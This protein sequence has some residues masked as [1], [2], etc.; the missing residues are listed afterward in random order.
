M[1]VAGELTAESPIYR[2]NARK[3]LFTRDDDG[4][5]RLVSLAGEISGTA[6]ALM[7]AFVGRSKNGR[8]VGLVNS[9]WS[10]LFGET[11]PEGLITKVEC[12]LKKDNYPKNNFFDLRMGIKLDDDRWAVESHKNYKFET[13]YRNSVFDFV[14]YVN[15]GMV[16]QKDNRTKL[17]YL[18][19]ELKAGRFWFGAG[20]SKG[21]GKC[22]LN[23]ATALQ[24]P[25][26]PPQTSSTAN[27][28]TLKLSFDAVNPL[29][30]GWPWGK[31]DPTTPSF[32]QVDG[33]F[34]IEGMRGLPDAIASR[35]AASM[36]GSILKVDEWKQQFAR[37][38][39][40]AIV[41]SLLDQP[42]Q[43]QTFYVLPEAAAKK[44]T[45]GKY[46]IPEK[47]INKVRSVMD[48]PYASKEALVA[49]VESLLGKDAKKAGKLTGQIEQ[50]VAREKSLNAANL[51]AIAEGLYFE[52]DVVDQIRSSF[53][54]ETALM[55]IITDACA[56]RMPQMNQD[57]DRQLKMLQSDPW[58]DLEITARREHL[59]IK[60]M[61]LEGKITEREWDNL[62]NPPGRIKE[63]VWRQFKTEH[64]KVAY[65]FMCHAGNLKKSIQNDRNYIE[66]LMHYRSQ[67]RQELAQQKN[68]DFRSGGKSNMEVSRKYGKPYDNMFMRMLVFTPSQ[69]RRSEWEVFI[70]GSTLKGAFRKRA[71]MV[72]NTLMEDRRNIQKVLDRLFGAQGKR[73]LLFFS[74]AYLMDP[75]EADNAFCS[76]D[77]VRMDPSTGRPVEEAKSDYLFLYGNDLRFT[78]QVDVQDVSEADLDVL[79]ILGHLIRDFTQGDIPIG[80]LKTSGFGW[81]GSIVNEVEWLTLDTR[82][83]HQRLFESSMEAAAQGLWRRVHLKDQEATEWIA[84]F[85]T[86]GLENTGQ[87][88]ST[89]PV[90]RA[91]EGFVSHSAFGG[92][93]GHLEIEGNTLTPMSIRE[94]GEP[95]LRKEVDGSTVYGWDF[96]SFSQP[97]AGLRKE[98]RTY[99][100]PSKSIKGMV[101]HIYS[102]GSNSASQSP[103]ISRLNPVDSLFGWVGGRPNEAIMGRVAFGFGVFEQP[104]LTWHKIPYPYG[105]WRYDGAAW[106]QTAGASSQSVRVADRWRVFP[107]APLAPFVESMEDFRPDTVQAVYVHAVMPGTRFRFSIRFWNL[108]KEELE[109]LIWCLALEDGLAHKMGSSRY[110]G[111]GSVSLRVL[112][113]SCLIDWKARYTK[114]AEQGWRVPLK[115]ADWMNPKTIANLEA[116]RKALLVK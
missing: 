9:M 97:E 80:S 46:A 78:F 8:N 106:K 74:D 49:E 93:C 113:E 43:E 23:L 50:Q 33:K 17:Y 3:T 104:R 39:P 31:L 69:Q 58:V 18:L 30:V 19:E 95:S 109:R 57:I 70:P 90:P 105:Q 114:G 63:S 79:G 36:G 84:S 6:Q 99:A 110:L 108:E 88:A 21:M 48:K 13:L 42:D 34:L 27:H 52:P 44:L 76:M 115:L 66:F 67:V 83:I 107:H 2:G 89:R 98:A 64:A 1:I 56:G 71:S 12:S 72:I 62:S 116:L 4:K 65:K 55:E 94:S 10:R 60:E 92:Y 103:D 47:V 20:K 15:D 28:L 25:A 32:A 11:M 51:K 112:P 102:I 101:R 100:V 45:K 16:Q 41:F 75:K 82:G 14:M 87:S 61:L 24:Q 85:I 53:Q 86:G 35:L 68:I 38:L 77:G 73:G 22:R 40:K 59:Q 5:Q 81:V 26:G 37:D 111:F 91:R 54:D 7:D 96:F 29:L